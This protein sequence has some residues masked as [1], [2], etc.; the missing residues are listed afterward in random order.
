MFLFL[1]SHFYSNVLS[2]NS[3]Y[4]YKHSNVKDINSKKMN[5]SKW[6][7]KTNHNIIKKAFFHLIILI[8]NKFFF[9]MPL[10]ANKLLFFF[11]FVQGMPY[12]LQ[13][14]Y[15]PLYFHSI[16]HLSIT[17]I[18]LANFLSFPWLI[19]F[20]WG[21]LVD[22]FKTKRFWLIGTNLSI[23]IACLHGVFAAYHGLWAQLVT[24]FII[25]FLAS[26]QD[27]VVDSLAVNLLSHEQ[28]TKAGLL[29]VE[30]YRNFLY[31]TY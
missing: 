14:Y 24:L 26:I 21:P 9:K 25:N 4:I 29:Q 15:L 18:T 27:V 11:Y 2:S 17:Q 1:K 20:I 19:K 12:G 22:S 13:S 23:L 16:L 6:E 30:N 3:S 31:C 5:K 8:I 10:S 7:W 28:L